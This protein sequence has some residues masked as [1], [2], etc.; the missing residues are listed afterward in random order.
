MAAG[1]VLGAG[2]GLWLARTVEMTK[3]PE[4]V[5]AFNGFGGGASALVAAAEVARYAGEPPRAGATRSPVLSITIGLSV[6]IGSVTFSGASSRSG[7]SASGSAGRPIS[8]PGDARR[9]RSCWR[10]A[11]SPAGPAGERHAFP[12]QPRARR[13]RAAGAGRAG[14]RARRAAGDPHRRGRHAGGGGAPQLVLRACRGHAAGFVLQLRA[15]RERRARRRQR[16]DPHPDHVR[17]DE[18]LARERAPRRVRGEGEGAGRKF[19]TEG[20]PCAA[21]SADDAAILM[22]YAQKVIVV[23]G[24]GLAVAQAQH[25]VREMADLL[26]KRRGR[27]EVRHPP[28]GRP[29][30]GPH[31]RPP[32]GGER[33]LRPAL[34]HGEVNA[35]FETTDVALVVGANDVVNPAARS[36]PG[37][38]IYGMPILNVDRS[39]NV[40]VLKRSMRPGYAGV[41]NLLI[42]PGQHADALRR[43][44]GLARSRRRG[45]QVPPDRLM[46]GRPRGRLRPLRNGHR[47]DPAGP[48]RWLISPPR[49]RSPPAGL[50]RGRGAHGGARPNSRELCRA[51]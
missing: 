32:G 4:L 2:V 3:M 35:D 41:D 37:S 21:T 8:F 27:G 25:E 10:W 51:R 43:C 20:S 39:R 42:L 26:Q 13:A 47:G 31:E 17:R 46:E 40:I 23:P 34:R 48:L 33:P 36:D 5:A 9:S 14:A 11:C 12:C 19:S 1:L 49:W 44:E 24:Y 50:A 28:G 38:P 16:A 30:A 22:S 29:D 7:S 45:A 6:L 18:P 15:H